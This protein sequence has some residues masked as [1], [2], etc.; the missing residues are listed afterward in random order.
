CVAVAR[1]QIREY[2]PNTQQGFSRAEE[3]RMPPESLPYLVPRHGW[4][5]PP[6]P[7]AKTAPTC[8]GALAI[9]VDHSA[10]R[11]SPRIAKAVPD[12][13]RHS[14]A[15]RL[16]PCERLAPLELPLVVLAQSV[17]ALDTPRSPHASCLMLLALGAAQ[18]RV[19]VTQAQAA[20]K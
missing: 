1:R 14:D 3:L 15:S 6:T 18:Q 7:D 8:R 11:R 16:Q 19:G 17:I 5:S 2:V 20:K 12:L 10:S 4:V 9:G 13:A